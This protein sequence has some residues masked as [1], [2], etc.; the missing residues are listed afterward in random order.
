[1]MRKNEGDRRPRRKS[2]YLRFARTVSCNAGRFADKRA[3]ISLDRMRDP[4]ELRQPG[5]GM[6]RD[7]CR[8]PMPWDQS[9]YAGFSTAEPWLPL[10]PGFEQKSVWAQRRDTQ[11]IYCLHRDLISLRRRHRALSIGAYRPIFC[12]DGVLVYERT[13]GEER[14]V[15]A[16]NLC[17][18]AVPSIRLTECEGDILLSTYGDRKHETLHGALDLRPH[19]GMIIDL[20]RPA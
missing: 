13:D 4:A 8:A 16:L 9:E 11:S 12:G 17:A 18:A 19:E 14:F 7:G 2:P 3:A 1:M 10:E 5:K 20:R 15:V 6:G